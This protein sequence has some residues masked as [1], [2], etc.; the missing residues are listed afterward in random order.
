MSSFEPNIIVFRCNF[1]SPAGMQLD[2]S[3]LKGQAN[4]RMVQTNCTGRIDPTYILEAFASG[5]D[6]V[7]VAGCGLGDC[8]F[9]TGNYKADRYMILLKK[10]LSQMGIEPERLKVEMNSEWQPCDVQSMLN[11]FIDK[12][13]GLG[14]ISKN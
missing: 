4:L 7:L 3:M 2:P 9:V 14:P 13:T 5:V 8:H 1:C 10:M 11:G 12:L 6:G